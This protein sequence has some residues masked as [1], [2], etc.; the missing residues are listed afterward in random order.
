MK[1]WTSNSKYEVVAYISKMTTPRRAKEL[2][3]LCLAHIE[4]LERANQSFPDSMSL[5]TEKL[6]ELMQREIARQVEARE[7]EAPNVKE[8]HIVQPPELTEGDDERG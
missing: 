6:P 5:F 3:R 7:I 2:L 4:V 8:L 1:E